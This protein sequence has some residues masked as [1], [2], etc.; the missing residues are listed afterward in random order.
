MEQVLGRR[1]VVVKRLEQHASRVPGLS[2]ATILGD[3]SV[4]FI[5]DAS[6]LPGLCPALELAD[7]ATVPSRA[8]RAA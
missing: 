1:Q 3:G 4:V 2:G 6:A 5:I 8:P 7:L